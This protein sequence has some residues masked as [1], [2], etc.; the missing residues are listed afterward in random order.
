[1]VTEPRKYRIIAPLGKGGFGTV[2][3]AEMVGAGGFK[4]AVA[5]KILNAD[6]S[7]MDEIV[8]RLRD[9]ARLL[10]MVRH[11]G[12]VHVDSLAQLDGR[13]TLVMEHIPGVGLNEVVRQAKVPVRCAVEI[14][15]RVADAL[16]AAH[17]ATDDGKPLH[18]VHRDM[19]PG[20]IIVA[21]SGEVKL[22]DFGVARAEFDSREAETHSLLFGSPDYMAPERWEF[23]DLPEG[24]VYSLGMVFY[25][26]LTGE[27]FG[28]SSPSRDLHDQKLIARMERLVG[29]AV[30]GV[31][32]DTAFQVRSSRTGAPSELLDLLGMML[33]FDP[34]SRPTARQVESVCRDILPRMPGPWLRDWA[35][36]EIPALEA[37]RPQREGD[38]VP[39]AILVE[40]S[41]TMEIVDGKIPVDPQPVKVEHRSG[42][43]RYLVGV[44]ALCGLVGVSLFLGSRL[45]RESQTKEPLAVAPE[46]QDPREALPTEPVTPVVV[47][48]VEPVPSV[49]IS[50][51]A[52]RKTEKKVEPP[53]PQ[54]QPAPVAATPSTGRVVVRGDAEEVRLV[55]GATRLPP[56]DVPPGSYTVEAR[57]PG[58]SLATAGR[59]TIAAGQTVTL[60]CDQS[61]AV[62]RSSQ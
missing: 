15:G 33:A 19:K 1:M 35:E 10:G 22:L 20:N 12:I 38:L 50:V 14:I 16:N 58:R 42:F 5:L 45:N 49:A 17:T 40:P 37:L 2:Y 34:E 29:S 48:P 53:P 41:G 6:V 44:L 7:G 56:G 13:W 21:P 60:T 36:R 57:F 26:V 39:G 9:E 59:V 4:K 32:D 23:R 18:L 52:A 55:S 3:R 8:R 62:C 43:L 46:V 47:A 27:R 31:P 54:P 30:G 25:E 51:P 11:S 28:R 61:F 24:D